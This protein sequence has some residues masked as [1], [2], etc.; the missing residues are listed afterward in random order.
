MRKK[1]IILG[2]MIVCCMACAGCAQTTAGQ[3]TIAGQ[4]TTAGQDTAAGQETAA[5]QDTAVGQD[6]ATGQETIAGHDTATG[7]DTAVGQTTTAGQ[8]TIAGQDAAAGQDTAAGQETSAG[9]TAS[10]Q[11]GAE[12]SNHMNYSMLYYTK[13]PNKNSSINIQYPNFT[14]E[15]ADQLNKM[16]YSKVKSFA[17]IDPDLFPADTG[18]TVDYQSAVT[19][20]NGKMASIIFWG[21]SNVS[22]SAHGTTNLYSLN[23]DLETMKEVT[24]KDLY[25]T[26]ADFEQ[27]FFQKAFFPS[28]PVTSYDKA[29]FSEMLKLQSP[30]DQIDPFSDNTVS[31]FLKPDGIVISLPAVHATGSDHFEAQLKYSDISQFYLPKDKYW[32]D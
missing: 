20:L 12:S 23:V 14:G 3:D 11:A 29:S 2:A 16:I 9:R 28:D 7:Q 1:K 22:G 4:E 13:A 5:G 25:T 31:C 19:L 18:L 8:E 24:L 10:D 30:E 6:T 26:D 17:Q 27:V 15:R 32:E 21:M